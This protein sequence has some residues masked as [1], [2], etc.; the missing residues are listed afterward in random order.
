MPSPGTPRL[1]SLDFRNVD[2]W[3]HLD[4]ER[5]DRMTMAKD[6]PPIWAMMLLLSEWPP[7][8]VLLRAMHIV[9]ASLPP[10]IAGPTAQR[11][12]QELS[13]QL[14]QEPQK[15]VREVL[16]PQSI[17]LAVAECVAELQEKDMV[18]AAAVW[19]WNEEL[20]HLDRAGRRGHRQHHRGGRPD[21]SAR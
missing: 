3:T 18:E 11:S 7:Q 19:L 10:R 6:I 20:R 8:R 13:Y 14:R 21:Q 5:L 9:A 2:E 16:L 4:A 12:L 17:Y 1:Y 15:L